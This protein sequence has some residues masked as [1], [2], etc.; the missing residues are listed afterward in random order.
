MRKVSSFCLDE[1][2]FGAILRVIIIFTKGGGIGI[3]IKPSA[4][5]FFCFMSRKS[6]LVGVGVFIILEIGM[7]LGY[8]V[9]R[10]LEPKKDKNQPIVSVVQK[11]NTQVTSSTMEQPPGDTLYSTTTEDINAEMGPPP[12]E[13]WDEDSFLPEKIPA[14]I[15]EYFD[16]SFD[17]PKYIDHGSWSSSYSLSA[18]PAAGATKDERDVIIRDLRGDIK[19]GTYTIKGFVEDYANAG[20]EVHKKCKEP[21]VVTINPVSPDYNWSICRMSENGD[22]QIRSDVFVTNRFKPC[23]THLETAV[24]LKNPSQTS[25]Y[26]DL[27][28]TIELWD[29]SERLKDVY[30]PKDDYCGISPDSYDNIKSILNDIN[31]KENLSERDLMML[32]SLEEVTNIIL[33][34]EIK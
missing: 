1:V 11:E 27:I 23:Y 8:L 22:Y 10:R 18:S 32:N 30:K 13:G 7:S 6:V 26:K 3:F 16:L 15:G 9:F 28:I 19:G 33:R 21:N 4:R 31:N 2:I 5:V 12:E 17:T 34:S 29:K 24:H 20:F 14:T 25:Q